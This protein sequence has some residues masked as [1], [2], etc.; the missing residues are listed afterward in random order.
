MYSLRAE[1]HL[2]CAPLRGS[3]SAVREQLNV[4][5]E[6][7]GGLNH[8]PPPTQKH[9]IPSSVEVQHRPPGSCLL[10]RNMGCH[11]VPCVG[12]TNLAT[13]QSRS[14]RACYSCLNSCSAA[15][16]YVLLGV[17]TISV[18]TLALG[19][20]LEQG[21]Q[22]QASPSQSP[23]IAVQPSNSTE[24]QPSATTVPQ[25]SSLPSWGPGR[26]PTASSTTP[27]TSRYVSP[28]PP[29]ASSTPTFRE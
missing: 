9:S 12:A 25:A 13:A 28:P 19:L 17:A 24:A 14:R 16:V 8:F 1:A 11:C 4:Q 20:A 26:A 6:R 15:R 3:E 23:P 22:P 18:I 27:L 7:A 29:T 21:S 2:P 10:F 5:I